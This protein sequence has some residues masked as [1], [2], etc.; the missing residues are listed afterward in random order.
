[1]HRERHDKITAE[2]KGDVVQPL[3]DANK[4]MQ[5]ACRPLIQGQTLCKH[6]ED[7]GKDVKYL[8]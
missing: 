6:A 7:A 8:E 1:M 2:P 3:N 4:N 5:G